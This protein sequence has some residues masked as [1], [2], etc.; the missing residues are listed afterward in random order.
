MERKKK[1]KW[2]QNRGVL[3]GIGVGLCI[4][5]FLFLLW[6]IFFPSQGYLRW[7]ARRAAGSTLE[8]SAS[9]PEGVLIAENLA[10]GRYTNS[11]ISFLLDDGTVYSRFLSGRKGVR[12]LSGRLVWTTASGGPSLILPELKDGPRMDAIIAD[13]G[14]EPI[15]IYIDSMG[16]LQVTRADG[17]VVICDP[18]YGAGRQPQVEHPP[19]RYPATP[20]DLLRTGRVAH[21]L[22]DGERVSGKLLDARF[23]E[24]K[25]AWGGRRPL[26]LDE[27]PFVLFQ[28]SLGEGAP[29]YLGR[30]TRQGKRWETVLGVSDT[31]LV[32]STHC[33]L[34]RNHLLVLGYDKH[35]KS[36]AV[37]VEYAFGKV[38]WARRIE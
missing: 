27:E 20:V 21:L 4:A 17:E 2:H 11:R 9:L 38:V 10:M 23:A 1:V 34:R 31:V 32:N 7:T 12:G 30:Y 5:F 18:G 24:I 36:L 8:S 15:E 35:Q 28:R 14:L 22:F 19:L 16:Y 13:C 26:F 37:A 33:F 25:T 6:A 29:V 3:T